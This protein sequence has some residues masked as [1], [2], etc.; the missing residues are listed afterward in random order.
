MP[1]NLRV[2]AVTSPGHHEGKSMISV[3]LA[4]AMAMEGKRVLLIDADM[5]CPSLHR[6]MGV[7]SDVGL[8]SVLTG[9]ARLEKAVF[10]TK[11]HN[12][13]C[14]PS[15][16]IPPNPTE[17]LNSKTCREL[18]RAVADVFD[19]VLVDCPPAAGLS[20]VQVIS[21]LVDGMLLVASMNQTLRPCLDIAIRTL[22]QA[23]A[24][25][26]GLVLN[27]IDT[28]RGSPGYYYYYANSYEYGNTVEG[29]RRQ[30]EGGAEPPNSARETGTASD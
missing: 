7:S 8:S 12:V 13:F 9:T 6:L 2:L 18:F 17:L 11:T 25:L 24:P 4:V 19:V 30:A 1:Q 29:G 26:V 27:R 23:R 3:N 28:S 14:L 21:G 22:V 15:G 20:D 10:R 5:R 16:P